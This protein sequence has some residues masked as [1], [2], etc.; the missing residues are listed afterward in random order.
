MIQNIVDKIWLEFDTDNS[1]FLEKDE[2]RKFLQVVLKDMD[3]DDSYED[4]RFEQTY[5]AIDANGDGVIKKEE[6]AYFIR[7]MLAIKGIR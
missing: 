2:T 4:S 6:M 5:A 7:M 1:G 3:V